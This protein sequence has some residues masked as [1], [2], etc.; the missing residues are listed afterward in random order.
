MQRRKFIKNAAVMAALPVISSLMGAIESCYIKANSRILLR[1]SWQTVNIGDI[2]HT[3]GIMELFKT[4]LPEAEITLW[5]NSLDNGVDVLLKKSFRNLKLAPERSMH[6][7]N[8]QHRPCNRHLKRA[9]SCYMV[10]DP[11]L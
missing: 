6:Q 1:S 4:Y 8:R 3:F 10:P 7:V 5:P 11:G 2:G 9:T